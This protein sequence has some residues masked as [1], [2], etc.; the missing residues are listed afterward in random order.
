MIDFHSHILPGIDDGSRSTTESIEL[1]QDER[2]QGVE[3]IVATPHF[4][5]HKNS[6]EGFLKGREKSVE[7]LAEAMTEAGL[8]GMKIDVG[9]EVYYFSGVSKAAM[10]PELCIRGTEVLL[11][12]MPFCQW[13]NAMYEEIKCLTEKRN[14]TVIL[15]H[16][17]RYYAYQKDKKIWH[18]IFALPIY[19]QIN[20]GSFLEWKKRRK[21]LGFLKEDDRIV[22]GSDC[23]NMTSRKPNLLAGR[24]VI[25]KKLGK[26]R[27][28]QIDALGERI[29]P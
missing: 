9:A 7:R 24:Q 1:L 23:H 27:L 11:L 5:A 16:I 14:L 13:D 4:Y 15:A 8:D 26:E 21:C 3:H 25:E 22:L 6:I 19:R 17:E 18:K 2:N 10:L 29:L 12:E 28:C 20:T